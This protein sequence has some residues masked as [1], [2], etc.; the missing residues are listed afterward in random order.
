MATSKRAPAWRR[1]FLRELARG[2]S[3][4]LAAEACGI[5][6]SSA[7]QARKRNAAFAASWERALETAR[8]RLGAEV[9]GAAGSPSRLREGSGVG[10]DGDEGGLRAHPQPLG[11]RPVSDSPQAGGEGKRARPILRANEVIRSSKKG[12]VCIA[13]AGE[14][15]WSAKSE[16]LFLEELTASANVRAAAQAAGVSTVTV[17]NRRKLWP[18]FAAQWEEAKAQ[19]YAR[20]EML[21][22]Q[23]ATATLDPEP[24]LRQAEDERQ[25]ANAMPEM[26]VE[27][28]LN[29]FRLHRA[30]Q[31]GGK[32]QRYG[33]RRREP[34]IE[35][36]RAEILRRVA[37]MEK[38]RDSRERGSNGQG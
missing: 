29:L 36:V 38:A 8:A 22:I 34:D 4:A 28:A 30:S 32:P 31:Q 37:A 12:R 19:G 11:L 18:E 1:V 24:V 3:V 14:G 10:A 25:D 5:D 35:E 15:R 21:L 7:Y 23:A 6:R 16:R 26:S 9:A 2:G 33:W 13:R 20:L 17:Y 27:Q